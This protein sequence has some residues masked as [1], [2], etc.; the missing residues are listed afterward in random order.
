MFNGEYQKDFCAAYHSVFDNVSS[1]LY[2]DTG[3]LVGESPWNMFDFA[4]EQTTILVGGLNR[5]D[6]FT[7]QRQPKLAPFLIK[8]RYEK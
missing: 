7:R 3:Y 2:P 8:N 6:L 5:K 4:T 1:I